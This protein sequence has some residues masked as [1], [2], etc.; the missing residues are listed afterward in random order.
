MPVNA[1]IVIA[2]GS[3]TSTPPLYPSPEKSSAM[4][5]KLARWS[6]EL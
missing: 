4:Q 6:N 1:A 3:A 2:T 5:I